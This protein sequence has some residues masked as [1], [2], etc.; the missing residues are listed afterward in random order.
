MRALYIK[1]YKSNPVNIKFVV[2]NELASA[3]LLMTN[4]NIEQDK[5]N[6]KRLIITDCTLS[7]Q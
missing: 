6:H 2:R 3:K 7:K 5:I 1:Y 4:N